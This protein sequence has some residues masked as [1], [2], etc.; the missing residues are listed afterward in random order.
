MV[1][2]VAK[3]I[4]KDDGGALAV[5]PAAFATPGT[6]HRPISEIPARNRRGPTAIILL[7]LLVSAGCNNWRGPGFRA[8]GPEM[9]RLRHVLAL[10]PGMS[11][12]DVGAGKGEVTVALAA[13]VGPSGHV[14]STEIDAEGLEQI[15]ATVAAAALAHVAIVA[16]RFV[17]RNLSLLSSRAARP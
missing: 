12:A 3:A 10:K 5:P 6:K 16:L 4:E 8:G 13:E 7:V 9:P 2:A 1:L 11:V 17:K 14:F 15:R